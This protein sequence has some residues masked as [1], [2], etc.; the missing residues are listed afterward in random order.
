MLSVPPTVKKV[1]GLRAPKGEPID[2]DTVVEVRVATHASGRFEYRSVEEVQLVDGSVA[3]RCK[4][5]GC[6]A[7]VFKSAQAV[8]MHRGAVHPGQSPRAADVAK[9]VEPAAE[10]PAQGELLT[11]RDFGRAAVQPVRPRRGRPPADP[12]VAQE[13][14]LDAVA[15]STAGSIGEFLDQVLESRERAIEGRNV[16][17]Q[18]AIR[19]RQ[20]LVEVQHH[21]DRINKLVQG[22][23]G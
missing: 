5:G 8:A 12:V 10:P 7:V 4:D 19:L 17:Q 3:Y 2:P 13:A 11:A 14:F 1:G 21:V 16:A 23:Q 20:T 9:K 22:I 6:K 18:E 15:R